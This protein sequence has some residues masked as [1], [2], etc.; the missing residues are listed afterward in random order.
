[1][2][3]KNIINDSFLKAKIKNLAKNK[4]HQISSIQNQ[5]RNQ[6]LLSSI[7]AKNGGYR[8]PEKESRQVRAKIDFR[9][10]SDSSVLILGF[11][12]FSFYKFFF[13]YLLILKFYIYNKKINLKKKKKK[14]RGKI[15]LFQ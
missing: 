5:S 14:E 10:W 1:M 12:F 3:G 11:P 15:A 13:F 9:V 2:I 7:M 4:K 8:S 6:F